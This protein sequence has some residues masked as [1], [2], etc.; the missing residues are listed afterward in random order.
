MAETA[1]ATPS[2]SRSQDAHLLQNALYDRDQL[3][4]NKSQPES[5]FCLGCGSHVAGRWAIV[6]QTLVTRILGALGWAQTCSYV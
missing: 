4:A 2:R 3:L 1:A 6:I 5:A